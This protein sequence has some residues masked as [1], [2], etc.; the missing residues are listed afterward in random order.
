MME[1]VVS[2]WV[3]LLVKPEDN[4]HD[5]P[6]K[7]HFPDF[8]KTKVRI[9]SWKLRKLNSKPVLVQFRLRVDLC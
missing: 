3:L 2:L 4:T 7:L 9:S 6:I 1:S 8:G 5:G